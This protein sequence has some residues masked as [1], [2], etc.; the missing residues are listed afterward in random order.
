MAEGAV[1]PWI[2]KEGPCYPCELGDCFLCVKGDCS[3]YI[4]AEMEYWEKLKESLEDEGTQLHPQQAE[5]GSGDLQVLRDLRDAE[6]PQE[7]SGIL[8]EGAAQGEFPGYAGDTS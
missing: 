6:A 2:R 7:S 8:V 4:A 3:C 5:H 1:I